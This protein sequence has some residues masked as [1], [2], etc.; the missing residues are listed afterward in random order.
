MS[1]MIFLICKQ[2]ILSNYNTT[3]QVSKT[4]EQGFLDQ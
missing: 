4:Y 2:E 3:L 1:F